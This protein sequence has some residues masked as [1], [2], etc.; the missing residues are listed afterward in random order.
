MNPDELLEY[1]LGRLEGPGR[2]RLERRIACD[3]DLAARLARLIRNLR[4]LLDDGEVAS[5]S[6]GILPDSI[7]SERPERLGGRPPEDSG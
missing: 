5:S 7:L 6:P 4:Q 2:E 1:A 3:P